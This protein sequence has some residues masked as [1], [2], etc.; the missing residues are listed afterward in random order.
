MRKYWW[1]NHK[2]T[3]KQ[4]VGEG[5]LWSPKKK[6]DGRP[7]HFYDNMRAAAPGDFVLSFADGLVAFVGQISDFA[8]SSSKPSSFGAT[9]ATWSDDGWHLPVKWRTLQKPVRPKLIMA[10]LAP[11]L[12]QKYAPIRQSGD[13]NQGA[14]LSEID[15][16]LFRLVLADAGVDI[17]LVFSSGEF[18]TAFGVTSDEIDDAIEQQLALS[19]ALS[20]TEKDQAIKARRGQGIFRSNVLAR[21]TSCRLTG[22]TNPSLLIASHIKPWRSCESSHER[23]DGDNGLMLTPHVDLLFD[24]GLI[25]FQDQGLLVVSKHIEN[26]DLQKLGISP[27]LA[28]PKPFSLGQLTYLNY[29][30]ENIFIF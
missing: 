1:V 10:S 20:A 7:S 15:F 30:R 4:E 5:Y 28:N 12:R 19:P 11:Y 3:V 27:I 29:H 6:A 9:G 18:I 16:D 17:D 21:E 24:R 2:Q 26:A 13:G 22:I 8:I 14:Y 25:T 23:L